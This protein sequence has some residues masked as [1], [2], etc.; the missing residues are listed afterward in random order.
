MLIHAGLATLRR[1]EQ[2]QKKVKKGLG[3]HSLTEFK[4]QGPLSN[5]LLAGERAG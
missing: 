5:A 3:A 4:I 2:W 1:E